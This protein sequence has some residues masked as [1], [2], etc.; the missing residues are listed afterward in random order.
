MLSKSEEERPWDG[1]EVSKII[2]KNLQPDRSKFFITVGGLLI[3]LFITLGI[4]ILSR[5]NYSIFIKPVTQAITQPTSRVESSPVEQNIPTRSDSIVELNTNSG[6]TYFPTELPTTT[7]SITLT[8]EPSLTK[9]APSTTTQKPTDP[10]S[11][12]PSRLPLNAQAGDTWVTPID[13][14]TMVY[15]PEGEFLMGSTDNGQFA[16]SDEK[17]QNLIY[18]DSFWIDRTEITKAMYKICV[19][20][21]VC[22]KPEM[23]A[24]NSKKEFYETPELDDHPMIWVTSDDAST[25]C[26]WVGRRLPTEAEWEKAARGLDGRI[27]PW[28]NNINCQY[29]NY[30]NCIGDTTPVGKYRLGASPFGVLDLAGNVREWVADYYSAD[31][32]LHQPYKNPI[33]PAS[34]SHVLKGGS[35]SWD[36]VKNVRVASRDHSDGRQVY[37]GFRCAV[38]NEQKNIDIRT[39]PLGEMIFEDYF[40]NNTNLWLRGKTKD[41]EAYIEN[42]K[43]HIV[44]SNDED[45][46]WF[47]RS[48]QSNFDDFYLETQTRILEKSS[49]SSDYGIYFRRSDDI[50]YVFVINPDEQSYT[51]HIVNTKTDTRIT[52]IDRHF[53]PFINSGFRY[54]KI[55]ILCNGESISFYINGQKIDTINDISSLSGDFGIFSGQDEHVIF[56]YIIVWEIN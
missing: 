3:V 10:P 38:S 19:E 29:A 51:L 28:G 50:N 25:Y 32:Y 20:A 56:N 39:I 17:P 43:Y 8:P 41:Y 23:R 14:M 7:P 9:E 24:S 42:Q 34:G 18:L 45:N 2:H 5:S 36:D 48:N 22:L 47:W 52:K 37:T 13:G 31:Y 33:G 6:S 35:Y 15:V 53:S 40:E 16:E 21:K 49:I 26:N 4:L 11:Q 12:D 55:G 1:R 44:G 27:Y 54:N 30:N 46:L